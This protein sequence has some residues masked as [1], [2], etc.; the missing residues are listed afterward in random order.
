MNILK[1]NIK[2]DK[3]TNIY[4][5]N[6]GDMN[7]NTDST[8]IDVDK[9]ILTTKYR[10]IH[11]DPLEVKEYIITKENIN[12]INEI[13]NKYNISSFSKLEMGDLFAYD[14]PTKTLTLTYD[15]SS[16]GCS[17][18]ESYSI[19]YYMKL[20]TKQKNQLNELTNY[21]LTLIEEENKIKE[22]KEK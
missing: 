11:S 21:M 22:Y 5:S 19:N 14:A 1:K 7:G 17:S 6:S 12:I 8:S 20:S 15:N 16:I 13:I 18:Y 3:L 9:L 2:N 4:Y 10:S